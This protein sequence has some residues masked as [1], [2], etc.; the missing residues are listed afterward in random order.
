MRSIH[1]LSLLLAA[2]AGMA[3]FACQS[4]GIGDPCIP[5]DEYDVTFPGGTVDQVDTESKSFQ[6][7]T[8]VCLRAYFNGRVSCPY[9]QKADLSGAIPASVAPDDRCYKP[10]FTPGTDSAANARNVVTVEVPPQVTARRPD[11]AVYCSCRCDGPDKGVRY[12]ECPDGYACQKLIPDLGLP[13]GQL[14]GSYCVKKSAVVT[15]P[16]ALVGGIACGDTPGNCGPNKHP[17]YQE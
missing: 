4:G 5:E 8:R 9:G 12:C 13:G 3:S 1:S 16:K 11:K 2:L 6:C 17:T 15:D 14:A 10:G 7:E